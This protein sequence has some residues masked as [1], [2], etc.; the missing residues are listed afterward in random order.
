MTPPFRIVHAITPA[1]VG[2]LESVVRLLA[3]GQRDGGNTVHVVATL[4]RVGV[5]PRV[6]EALRDSGVA[7]TTVVAPGRAYLHEWR[8]VGAALAACSPDIVHT[9]GYRAD[10]LV[11]AL[12]RRAGLPTV[13]TLHG[14][15]GG[16]WKLRLYEKLQL[17]ALKRFDG[18]VA[19]SEKMACEL[20][21]RV[22]R[23]RLHIIPNAF[24]AATRSLD[25][26]EARRVL[27]IPDDQFRL[28]W[29]GRLSHEKG[30]DIMV[31]ALA[32]TT[33]SGA[34]LSFIGSGPER[35][36]VEQLAS[37]LGVL[38]RITFHG[39]RQDAASLLSA[40][41][42]VVLSS[43]TEGTP[44]VLLEALA[45]RTPV[46]ATAVGGIPDVVQTD[47]AIVVPP[48][49]PTAL[50]AAIHAVRGDAGGAA[51][52]AERGAARLAERYAVGPWVQA[53]DRI[54]ASITH[55]RQR[56]VA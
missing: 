25:R 56:M 41:D 9:H 26:A 31:R 52:R 33:A 8:E 27:G 47:H 16:D 10:L 43:R 30:P 13:T 14:F 20:S 34:Y 7:V 1:E 11:G 21:S 39:V 32:E 36:S 40:F 51:D 29:V 55:D 35:A 45:S 24:A 37:E 3:S 4:D 22:H 15:T 53:Y 49:D 44:I 6:V 28:G 54:Y 23:T 38:S 42:A 17:R 46:L 50:A 2:G 18:V 12:G 5:T 19:V 48:L